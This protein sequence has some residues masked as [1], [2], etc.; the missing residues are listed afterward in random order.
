MENPPAVSPSEQEQVGDEEKPPDL[1]PRP[2]PV[3]TV[4]GAV[5]RCGLFIVDTYIFR[6]YVFLEMRHALPHFIL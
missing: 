5:S 1:H 4:A 2:A 3:F 6:K